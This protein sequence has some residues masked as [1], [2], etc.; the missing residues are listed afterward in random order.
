MKINWLTIAGLGLTIA[1][2]IVSSIA[3]KKEKND[4]IEKAVIKYLDKCKAE[5][6]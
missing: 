3:D 5:N 4:A 1:G 6:A 2:T